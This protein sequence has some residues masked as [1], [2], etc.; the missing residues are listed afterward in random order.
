MW[1]Q[2]DSLAQLPT[3]RS[4]PKNRESRQVV[5]DSNLSDGGKNK[6]RNHLAKNR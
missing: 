4:S 5:F 6:L 2:T 1:I 3:S